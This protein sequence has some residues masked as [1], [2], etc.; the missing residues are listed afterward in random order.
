MR[1]FI[2]I[3]LPLEIKDYLYEL[4]KTIKYENIKVRFVSKK[5]LHLTLKFFGELSEDKVEQLKNKL[6]EIECKKFRILLT[7]FGVFPSFDYMKVIWVGIEKNVGLNELQNV[8]DS[9]TLDLS[10]SDMEHTSHLTLGRVIKIKNK[11][12]VSKK[13]K[14]IKIKP[15]EFT[16]NEFQLIK[17]VLKKEGPQYITLEKYKLN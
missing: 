15:M 12:E 8:I 1:L 14:T 5:N 2:A 11:E 10:K 16:V 13:L 17:S 6:K 7:N 4:Q 9:E 3:D